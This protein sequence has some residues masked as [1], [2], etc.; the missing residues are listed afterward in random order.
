MSI[1]NML[2]QCPQDSVLRTDRVPLAAM[3]VINLMLQTMGCE[4]GKNFVSL[5]VRRGDLSNT[6]Q[7][8]IRRFVAFLLVF[9]TIGIFQ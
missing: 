3:Q 2:R 1:N 5:C 6:E 4:E 8:T 9:N 7:I